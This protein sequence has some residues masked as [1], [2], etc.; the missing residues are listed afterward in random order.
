MADWTRSLQR[1][2]S[3]TGAQGRLVMSRSLH[4]LLALVAL[5]LLLP[6]LAQAASPTLNGQT[7]AGSGGTHDL[8]NG[9]ANPPCG[10]GT[11]EGTI[12]FTDIDGLSGDPY[13]GTF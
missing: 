1:T 6:P 11:G 10:V 13:L 8:D 2:G 12:T 7:L 4:A 9:G 3:R 5:A